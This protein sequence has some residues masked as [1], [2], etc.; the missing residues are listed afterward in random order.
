[1]SATGGSRAILAAMGANLGIAVTKFVAAFLSGSASTLAEGVHSLADTGN[2][3]L[4]LIGRRRAARSADAEHPFGYGRARFLAAFV[5]SIML[6]TV[7]GVFSLFTGWEKLLDPRPVANGWLPLVVLALAIGLESFSLRTA[8]HESRPLKGAGSWIDFARR[9][10]APELPVVLLE[11]TAALTGLGVAVL[12]VGLTVVT[13][14]GVFDAIATLLIGLLLVAVALLLGIET[15]SLLIGEGA[16]PG[17]VA[18]IRAAMNAHPAVEA[19]IHMKTLYLGPDEMLVAAKI[20]LPRATRLP[21]IA[22]AIDRIESD[23]RRD[24]PVARVIYIEPD[25]YLRAAEGHPSTDSIVIKSS[26]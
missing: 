22:A 25:I 9:A 12:G 26:D 18:R 6:F 15:R 1:M 3:I 7:G 5:V 14:N 11:D 17:D 2:Q 24:V 10:K 21:E 4:L 8:V 16:S 19:I 13:G 20:A 23:I